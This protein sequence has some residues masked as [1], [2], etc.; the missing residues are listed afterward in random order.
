[1]CSRNRQRPSG[2]IL[3]VARMAEAAVD[4][5]HN[6]RADELADRGL[7]ARRTDP[8]DARCV[9]VSASGEGL[10]LH[11]E[12]S[13]QGARVLAGLTADWAPADRRERARLVSRFADGPGP[14]PQPR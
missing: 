5:P 14:G 1:M 13:G 8:S 4:I 6:A 3:H 7:V 11:R 10:S 9:L 2:V 12:V